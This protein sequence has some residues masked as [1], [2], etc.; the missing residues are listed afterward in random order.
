MATPHVVGL[1]L[2]LQVYENLSGAAAI[3]S[4]VKAL[5][6]SGRISGSLN[7]SPNLLAY[8]GNGA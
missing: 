6:T 8:N 4:R 5:G 2:Y 3:T 7:S 1:V